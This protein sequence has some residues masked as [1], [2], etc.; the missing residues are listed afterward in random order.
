MYIILYILYGE[1]FKKVLYI[2]YIYCFFLTFDSRRAFVK[3]L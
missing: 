1:F 3:E 2:S